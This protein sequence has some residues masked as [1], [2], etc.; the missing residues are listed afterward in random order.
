MPDSD[1]MPL[2]RF[3]IVFEFR[4]IKFAGYKR[5]SGQQN[6]ATVD[7]NMFLE[8]CQGKKPSLND[9]SLLKKQPI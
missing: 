8:E 7:L 5:F 6:E 1:F 4:L 3:V 2:N 9:T